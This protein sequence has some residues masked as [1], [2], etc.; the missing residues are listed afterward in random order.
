LD[1]GKVELLS[2]FLK[3]GIPVEMTPV[4]DSIRDMFFGRY[5]VRYSV[6]LL[7]FGYGMR[8]RMNGHNVVSRCCW[9]IFPLLRN[10]KIAAKLHVS[11]DYLT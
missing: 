3:I 11:Y 2:D 6:P 7:F 10:C 1:F 9:T 4:P 8:W 5:V